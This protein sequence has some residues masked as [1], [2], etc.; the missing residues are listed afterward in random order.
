MCCTG[1]ELEAVA[2]DI[3]GLMRT[4]PGPSS[5]TSCW[6]ARLKSGSWV[7]GTHRRLRGPRRLSWAAAE[8]EPRP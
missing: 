1:A 4:T 8:V 7:T 6:H 2:G 3:T 5:A